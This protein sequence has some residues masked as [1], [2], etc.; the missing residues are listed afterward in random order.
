[1]LMDVGS[2]FRY[3]VRGLVRTPGLTLGIILTLAVGIGAN[4]M[5]FS[6]IDALLLRPAM[7]EDPE[8]LVQVYSATN[9]ARARFASS[10]YPDY[11]DL[12]DQG[13]FEGSAAFASVSLAL[14][15][16]GTT[17]GLIGQ[18]V[19]GNYFDVVGVRVARGRGFLPSEDQASAPAYVTVLSDAAWQK[20]LCG[21]SRTRRPAHHP[22]RQA[23]YCRRHCAAALHG[24][25]AR[26]GSRS[27]GADGAP[28]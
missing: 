10:S 2:D 22:K 19:S 7:V 20:Y 23:L 15:R 24:S 9:D 13:G 27:L 3:A 12:R 21:R 25:R 26:A 4:A 6:A 17:S 11:V 18:V 5:I 1:M 28:A 14:D 16:D 8:Q